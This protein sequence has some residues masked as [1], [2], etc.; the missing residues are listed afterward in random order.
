MDMNKVVRVT[1]DTPIK[2]RTFWREEGPFKYIIQG[3]REPDG[4]DDEFLPTDEWI[5]SNSFVAICKEFFQ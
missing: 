2:F 3:S 1:I 5:F 4:K